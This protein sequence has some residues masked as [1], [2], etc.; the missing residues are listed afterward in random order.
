MFHYCRPITSTTPDINSPLLPVQTFCS[1]ALSEKQSR[2][3]GVL[4]FPLRFVYDFCI[5]FLSH[6]SYETGEDDRCDAFKG[7]SLSRIGIQQH[8][9][10][11]LLKKINTPSRSEADHGSLVYLRSGIQNEIFLA[12]IRCSEKG[13]SKPL[14]LEIIR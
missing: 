1:T 12:T 13:L 2:I 6:T 3:Y 4:T 11:D 7:T 5:S 10:S 8:E 14:P 9:F